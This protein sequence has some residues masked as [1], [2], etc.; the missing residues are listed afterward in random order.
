[1]SNNVDEIHNP[2]ESIN[3]TFIIQNDGNAPLNYPV[4][5]IELNDGYIQASNLSADNAYYLDVGEI[6]NVFVEISTN[7]NTPLG[8]I[9]NGFLNIKFCG[10]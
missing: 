9:V 7:E 2:G 4:V 10:H 1:M 5:E 6:M 8:H 3:Y